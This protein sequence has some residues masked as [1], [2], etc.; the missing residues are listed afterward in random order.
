MKI[1]RESEFYQKILPFKRPFNAHVEAFLSVCWNGVKEWSSAI[2]EW[3]ISKIHFQKSAEEYFVQ[4]VE[5]YQDDDPCKELLK[6]LV[7]ING[8]CSR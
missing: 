6:I 4:V 3:E 7:V 8:T 5:Q 2:Q 1:L